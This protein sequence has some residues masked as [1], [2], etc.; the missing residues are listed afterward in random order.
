MGEPMVCAQTGQGGVIASPQTAR[1]DDGAPVV[2]A[3]RACGHELGRT[4]ARSLAVNGV[5]LVQAAVL[6]CSNCGKR[7][8]WAPLTV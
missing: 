8:H 1:N 7:R 4:T 6:V 2:L 5:V 3:C